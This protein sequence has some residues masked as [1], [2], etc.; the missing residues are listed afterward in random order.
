M[1]PPRPGTL[2]GWTP[3][4]D[5]PRVDPIRSVPQAPAD[6]S[7]SAAVADP[8]P[9]PAPTALV[10]TISEPDREPRTRP[11]P[12]HETG[13][14]AAL[15]ARLP[16][17]IRDGRLD[18]SRPGVIALLVVAL[19]AAALA[20]TILLRAR[21]QPQP[22]APPTVESPPLDEQAG[23]ARQPPSQLVVD[24][25]GKVTRPGLVALP[26]G[27]RVADALQAAGGADRTADTS[28][29]NLA[30][31]LV[32]GEQ[33]LVG[34]DPPPGAAPQSPPGTPGA[35]PLDLNAATVEQLDALPGVGPVLAQRIIDWRT[36]HGGF[37]AVDQLRE[38][39]GIG[40]A[41]FADLQNVVAVP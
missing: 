15:Q 26:S 36:E 4:L 24:V 37:A 29:L 41:R 34:I 3:D 21:P 23:A 5:A 17:S 13:L 39:T 25:A 2:G 38:V 20:G 22:L 30:R 35:G 31:K 32:D 33:L 12:A 40:E 9:I 6:T 28:A 27:A 1:Q 14:A 18:H 16:G 19:L 11:A 8:T 7:S 10:S